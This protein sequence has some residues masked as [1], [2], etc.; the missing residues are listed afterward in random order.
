MQPI[1]DYSEFLSEAKQGLAEL[2][3]LTSSEEQLRTEEARLKKELA[4]EQKALKDEID[5]NVKQRISEIN[6]NYDGEISRDRDEL[7]RVKS[8]REKA[9]TQGV[10]ERIKELTQGKLEENENL[11]R[12]LREAF[13]KQ[14]VPWFYRTRLY[15]RLFFPH[16]LGD[17]LT[18]FL[19]VVVCFVAIPCGIYFFLLPE[20]FRHTLALVGIYIACILLFGGLYTFINSSSK[21]KYLES[22]K[23]GRDVWDQ[24]IANRKAVARITKNVSRD[25]SDEGYDLASFDDEIA[26]LTHQIAE[27]T[28]KKEEAL[29]QFETVTKTILT[30]ELTQNARPRIEQLASDHAVAARRLTETAEARQKRRLSLS[31]GYE[32]YL[33]KEFMTPERIDAL[34]TIMDSGSAANL[35]EAIQQYKNQQG[36]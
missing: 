28:R 14:G 7:N 18:L 21:V 1:T 30:D 19:F 3:Q 26:R 15:Y 11:R 6:K 12:E 29:N 10:K 35:S 9:R 25:R 22:L 16:H 8:R 5:L 20:Q 24:I 32:T 4:A 36:K 2:D 33:G 13:Q 17:F 23:A 31:D 34:K 27:N